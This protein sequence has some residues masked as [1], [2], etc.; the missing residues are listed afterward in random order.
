[1]VR[2]SRNKHR[3]CALSLRPAD[4]PHPRRVTKSR[5]H[6]ARPLLFCASGALGSDN[7]L[8]VLP[9]F[10]C[11]WGANRLSAASLG[12]VISCVVFY[13]SE[14]CRSFHQPQ[15]F[16]ASLGVTH[17]PGSRLERARG[18]GVGVFLTSVPSG[19]IPFAPYCS[20]QNDRSDRGILGHSC[21]ALGSSLSGCN[22]TF[23][24]TGGLSRERRHTGK[25]APDGG[26]WSIRTTQ[27]YDRSE[28]RVMFDEVMKI[29][30]EVD[31]SLP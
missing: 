3:T 17:L 27:L 13:N 6:P 14:K 2:E 20:V 12:D 11:A 10:E 23:R 18:V 8:T 9:N 24:G 15:R 7:R 21:I 4:C 30:I 5:S 25:G 26:A 1:M 19:H 29:Y 31:G 28:D 16:L 22:H